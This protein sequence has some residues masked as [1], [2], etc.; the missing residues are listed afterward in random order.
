MECEGGSEAYN[1]KEKREITMGFFQQ[2]L[3]SNGVDDFTHMLSG[4]I[5]SIFSNINQCLLAKHSVK[6][7]DKTLK[8]MGPKKAPNFD[9]FLY[10]SF[11][12][13]GTLFESIS[14]NIAL[15]F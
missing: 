12:G 7:V 9:G 8:E 2:L 4:I 5:V 6:K 13:I 15:A 10:Y 3:S 14:L 1:E 11:N